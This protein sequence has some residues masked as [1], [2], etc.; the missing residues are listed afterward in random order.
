MKMRFVWD[1]AKAESNHRK[2]GVRFE[3]AVQVFF[4]PLH[5]TVQDRVEGGEYRW[6]TIGQVGG[7]A[8]LLVAHTVTEDGPEPV[9]VIRIISVR[10]ATPQER[11]RYANG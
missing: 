8:V 9:E 6:Q 3:D 7:A 4:D 11:K 2:H 5:L 1:L 10:R